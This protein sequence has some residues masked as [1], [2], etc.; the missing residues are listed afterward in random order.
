MDSNV[1]VA[2]SRLMAAR[3]ADVGA[4]HQLTLFKDRDHYLE[5]AAVRT[6]L[7]SESEGFLRKNLGM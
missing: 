6:Q 4:P 1:D 2:Q 7:L 3:L 5:D